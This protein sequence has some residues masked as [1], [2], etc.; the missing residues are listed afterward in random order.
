VALVPD[1][2]LVQLAAEQ[3]GLVALAQHLFSSQAVAVMTVA[4]ALRVQLLPSEL[5]VQLRV[6]ALAQVAGLP[7][8]VQ[9]VLLAAGF[10]F[11]R[12]VQ[13][14]QAQQ[15]WLHGLALQVL[16]RAYPNA[17]AEHHDR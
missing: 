13:E 1:L 5:Q 11:L 17:S 12:Q 15:E 14:A 9:P 6:A 7:F 8:L 3:G 2:S 4:Q 16:E 10:L